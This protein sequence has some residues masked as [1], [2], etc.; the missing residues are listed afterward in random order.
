MYKFCR[1][2]LCGKLP[3]SIYHRPVKT[4]DI[5]NLGWTFLL[6]NHSARKNVSDVHN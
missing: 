5:S 6:I 3:I 1:P 2:L 4:E